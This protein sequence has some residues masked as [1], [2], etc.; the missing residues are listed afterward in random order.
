M[1]PQQQA[2]SSG[3]GRHALFLDCDD[4]LYDNAF[5]TAESL[6][7]SI[8]RYCE[9]HLGISHEKSFALYK[10]HGTCLKGLEVEGIAH[11]RDH[12]LET[13]HDVHLEFGEDPHLRK[14]LGRLNHGSVDVRV[15][16]ASVASH[17]HRCLNQLGVAELLVTAERPIIDVK[18]VG[19]LSKHH[20]QAFAIAQSLVQQPLPGLCTLVDDNWA[21]IRAAKAAGWRTV[22]VGHVSRYGEP[23]IELQEADHVI[24]SIHELPRVLPECFVTA[25]ADGGVAAPTE[26]EAA[27]V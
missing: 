12:F 11:D 7:I 21:N 24:G 5:K 1:S 25:A 8:A 13:V 19:F 2:A 18:S 17:A 26:Q 6:T 23:A 20:G 3:S 9:R 15:F 16:T 22:V 4:T 14:M 10:Q 27:A